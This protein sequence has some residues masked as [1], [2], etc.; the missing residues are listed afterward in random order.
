MELLTT[1]PTSSTRPSSDV[2][3]IFVP[4]R[5]MAIKAPVMAKGIAIMTMN[6]MVMDSN[7]A[8]STRNTSAMATMSALNR[9]PNISAIVSARPWIS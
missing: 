2:R 7:C 5:N 3:D 9:L 1:V 4:V 8:A 6:A